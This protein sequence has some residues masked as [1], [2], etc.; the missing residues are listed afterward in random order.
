MAQTYLLTTP[1]GEELHVE[2]AQAG[3]IITTPG[4]KQIE[5]PPLR[6]LRKLP[7]VETEPQAQRPGWSMTQSMMFVP[8]L[9]LLLLSGVGL[10]IL[11]LITPPPAD[12]VRMPDSV[13]EEEVAQYQVEDMLSFWEFATSP[14]ALS[15]V[16]AAGAPYRHFV[17]RVGLWRVLVGVAIG[18]IV[19]GIGLMGL[20]FAMTGRQR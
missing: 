12:V 5:I 14:Q 8:G 18:G 1:D 10:T 17:N 9:L 20:S 19:V 2:A 6:E 11:I 15:D 7:L 13:I 4:G 16:R 3:D